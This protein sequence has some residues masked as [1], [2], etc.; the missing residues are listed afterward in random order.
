M[1][2]LVVTSWFP[3]ASDPVSGIFHLRDVEL[4]SADHEVVVL[5]LDENA[6]ERSE[7]NS[8]ELSEHPFRIIRFP[9]SLWRPR[10]LFK[11]RRYLRDTLPHF[12]VVHT[13]SGPALIPFF[14]LS[15]KQKW[16]H[17]EHWGAFTRA[18]ISWREKISLDLIKFSYERPEIVV[19]VSTFLESALRPIRKNAI[20]VIGNSVTPSQHTSSRNRASNVLKVIGVGS[21]TNQK[22]ADIAVESIF[23]LKRHGIDAELLWLGDGPLKAEC[24]KLARELGISAQVRFVGDVPNEQVHQ[25]LSEA[26][27]FIAPTQSETFGVAIAE[28]M[29]SG[30]PVVTGNRGGFI[31]FLLPSANR[32]LSKRT[33]EDFAAALADLM[34]S[35]NLP[36]REEIASYARATFDPSQRT[37]S[38]KRVY[39]ALRGR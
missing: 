30:L 14:A 32:T 35:E 8:S 7:T 37:E 26:D 4:L 24:Q 19:A 25:D 31:D 28:A 11:A 18:A 27:I 15:V 1:K 5:H 23:Y 16:V 39:S 29:M 34:S 13:M 6:R 21:V 33:G 3:K 20:S 38:Y 36:S 12:D 2:V 9:Y 22:G 10:S 17:T